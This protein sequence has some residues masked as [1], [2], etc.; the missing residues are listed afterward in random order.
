[1]HCPECNFLY[2]E[3]HSFSVKRF[4]SGAQGIP[5]LV[6]AYMGCQSVI[7]KLPADH[8]IQENGVLG[9]HVPGQPKVPSPYPEMPPPS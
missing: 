5:F 9:L 4:M 1:M 8:E 2:I 7:R 3:E 6:S